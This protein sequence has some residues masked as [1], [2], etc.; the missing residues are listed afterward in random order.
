[1]NPPRS[2]NSNLR[3]LATLILILP[4]LLCLT[5]CA[6]SPPPPALGAACGSV[7]CVSVSDC[8]S[9][10]NWPVCAK[11]NSA[12]CFT[13]THEC[14]YQLKVDSACPCLER[15]VRLCNVNAT[16]PGVQICTANAGRTYTFWGTCTACQNCT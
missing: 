1:M 8:T 3:R 11:L 13:A 9:A 14:T 12:Q 7:A 15:D 2:P 10:A 5:Q 4:F 6:G 16:T